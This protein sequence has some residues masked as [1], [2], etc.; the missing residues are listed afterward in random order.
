[1]EH[2]HHTCYK[3][4]AISVR[5]RKP[6]M[7]AHYAKMRILQ[8]KYGFATQNPVDRVMQ[9]IWIKFMECKSKVFFEVA[10]AIWLHWRNNLFFLTFTL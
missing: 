3:D 9:I 5:K 8:E 2:L 1:M 4:C 7:Y 6:P 10:G